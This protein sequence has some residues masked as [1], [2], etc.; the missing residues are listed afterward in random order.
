MLSWYCNIGSIG[1][2]VYT[3]LI[4]Y[5]LYLI[6]PIRV[7]HLCARV[8]LYSLRSSSI[9]IRVYNLADSKCF[10][11]DDNLSNKES[12]VIKERGLKTLIHCS[13]QRKNGKHTILE[14]R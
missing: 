10:I 6:P 1:Y 7:V 3:N 11:C 5:Q 2:I 9:F 12:V 13:K 14:G 8:P 4:L